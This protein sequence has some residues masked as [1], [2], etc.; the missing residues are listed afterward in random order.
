MSHLESSVSIEIKNY[1]FLLNLTILLLCRNK[2]NPGDVLKLLT[3]ATKGNSDKRSNP[4][5]A[6]TE[7]KAEF[8][9]PSLTEK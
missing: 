8:Y 4:N 6:S 3:D 5:P 2:Q 7:I 1:S 9:Y